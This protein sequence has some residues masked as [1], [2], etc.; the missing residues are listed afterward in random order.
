MVITLVKNSLLQNPH[1]KG[2]AQFEQCKQS[3]CPEKIQMWCKF[4]FTTGAY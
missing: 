4:T 3:S 1:Y 2:S